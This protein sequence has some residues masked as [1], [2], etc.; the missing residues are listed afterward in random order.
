MLL[1]GKPELFVL[2]VCIY[3][4]SSFYWASLSDGRCDG[5]CDALSPSGSLCF[6]KPLSVQAQAQVTCFSLAWIRVDKK[7]KTQINNYI[8]IVF[9]QCLFVRLQGAFQILVV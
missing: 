7:Q 1:V 2:D 3:V 4:Q 6:A 5:R 9:I 8:H